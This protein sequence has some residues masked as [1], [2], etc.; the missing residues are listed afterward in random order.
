MTIHR[1]FATAVPCAVLLAAGGADA[2]M[3][4]VSQTR[5]VRATANATSNTEFDSDEQEFEAPDEGPFVEGAGVFA[6]TSGSESSGSGT[7]NSS[8]SPNLLQAA[9]TCGMYA[10]S[11]EQNAIASASGSS[12]FDV[13]FDVDTESSFALQGTISGF[14]DGH[15]DVLLSGPGGVIYEDSA[16][17]GEILLDVTGSMVP[18]QYRLKILANGSV[19]GF[20]A[21]K[22]YAS[23]DFDATLTVQTVV[24]AG[25]P[26]RAA[27][28]SEAKAMYR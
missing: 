28:W 10:L 19:F 5:S 1:W 27:T 7:Q 2:A 6:T 21:S 17:N 15:T 20:F 23:G 3:T 25:P 11:Y 16:F 8:L 14:D 22:A 9:G 13:T 24:S 18:G 4:I 26:M 12:L